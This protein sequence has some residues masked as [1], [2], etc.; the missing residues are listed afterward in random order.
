MRGM[1]WSTCLFAHFSTNSIHCISIMISVNNCEKNYSAFC[2]HIHV[3][4]HEGHLDFY[5][6]IEGTCIFK[7]ACSNADDTLLSVLGCT[8][9]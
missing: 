3:Q 4:L 1:H 7:I 2:F 9:V 6:I 5:C 8:V